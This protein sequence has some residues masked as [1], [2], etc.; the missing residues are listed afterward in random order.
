MKITLLCFRQAC[1]EYENN[2]HNVDV[3]EGDVMSVNQGAL[4]RSFADKS[5]EQIDVVDAEKRLSHSIILRKIQ[6]FW[7]IS[8]EKQIN[9]LW[10]ISEE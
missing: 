8:E 1:K 6:H 3:Q 10:N 5:N 7:N 9:K 2:V 4:T